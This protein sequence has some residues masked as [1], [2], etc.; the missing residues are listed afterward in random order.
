MLITVDNGI[1]SVEGVAEAK[2]LGL[3]VLV[4]DHHLP[5]PAAACGRRHRQPQPARLPFESK[6]MAGVGVMFYVLLALR[7][8]LRARGV[9]TPPHSLSS[10][11]C[12]PW[13]PWAP[14]PMWSSST[15]TTAAWWPQ[16]SR[17]IRAGKCLRVAAL[18]HVAGRKAACRHHVRLWLCPGPAHQRRRRLAD[19]TL[20]IECLLTDDAGRAAELA[21]TLDGINRERRE[22]EGGMREQAMLMAESLFDESESPARHQRVRTRL[23]RRRGRHRGQ[24]HR[25]Q[26]APP[27]LC[28]CGQQCAGQKSTSSRLRP[29]HPRFSPARCAGPRWPKRHPGVILKFGGHAM[30][31]GL[32]GGRRSF[33]VFEQALPRSRRNGWTP[34]P[35]PARSKPTAPGPWN[36]A[37]PTSWTCPCT[38]R[39]GARAFC[40]HLQRRGAG[41]EPAPGGRGQEP[42]SIKLIHQGNPVDAIWFGR[43][44][45]LPARVL[46]AFR[47]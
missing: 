45:P 22:I 1:A 9:L 26:A 6:S 16:G 34:P 35:S 32:H 25:G 44:E 41:A 31:A 23:S 40:P 3:Q 36:I 21:A 37:A 10:T 15:P 39:C 30:A 7:A 33:D 28:V 46:L 18:F 47:R 42:P 20:G 17:R 5:G 43:T 14:W 29:L 4:T 27:H 13:S 24:P 38:A 11:R 12:S 8:E 19:M 2:A